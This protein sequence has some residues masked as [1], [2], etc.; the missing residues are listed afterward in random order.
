MK[1]QASCQTS[2]TDSVLALTSEEGVG[3]MLGGG[4][5]CLPDSRVEIDAKITSG[6]FSTRKDGKELTPEELRK[7]VGRGWEVE[8]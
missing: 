6:Y 5:S 1:F 7:T 4:M 8:D 3:L 2:Y